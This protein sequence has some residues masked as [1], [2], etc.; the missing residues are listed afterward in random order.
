MKDR[1][2]ILELFSNCIFDELTDE[3]FREN[4]LTE[5]K[6]DYSDY[7]CGATKLVLWFTS[8]PNYVIKIPFSGHIL[9]EYDERTSRWSDTYIP[10][11]G[12]SA[13]GDWNYC[14]KEVSLYKKAKEKNVNMFFLETILVGEIDNY[15][16]YMQKMCETYYDKEHEDLS[17]DEVD[18]TI[19]LCKDAG[20]TPLKDNWVFDAI[21]YYGLLKVKEFL[22]FLHNN[23]INDLHSNNLG[24]Y[25]DQPIIIDYAGYD[26]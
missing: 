12:A 1:D 2:K 25:K 16:I 3:N 10:F 13:K 23:K 5:L 21:Q 15:P 11:N 18:Y 4:I 9:G 17:Y 24:Y 19:T 6:E 14:E 26:Y 22:K 7:E 20:V 8:L